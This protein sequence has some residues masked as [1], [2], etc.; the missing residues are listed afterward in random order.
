MASQGSPESMTSHTRA[1]FS[2][3]SVTRFVPSGDDAAY[4]GIRRALEGPPRRSGWQRGQ[5]KA[6]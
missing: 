5:K 3:M 2:K 1:R 4:H 6:S